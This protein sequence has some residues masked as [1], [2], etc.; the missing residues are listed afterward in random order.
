MRRRGRQGDLRGMTDGLLRKL[1]PKGRR[2][3]SR[4]AMAWREVAGPEIA[5]HTTGS[6][7]REGELLVYVDSP[8]WAHELSA[9]A[10]HMRVRLNEALGEELVRSVRFAVSRAVRQEQ[11]LREEEVAASRYYAEDDVE[12]VPLS[13]QEHA[14]VEFAAGNISDER[15]R[16]AVVRAMTR[17]LEWKKGTRA[18]N[19]RENRSE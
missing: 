3:G 6:A 5:K 14:Q 16:E 15:L 17:H 4:A 2:F 11:Q 12:P 9:M 18:R 1:D 19:G 10:E 8:T 13:E 7:L